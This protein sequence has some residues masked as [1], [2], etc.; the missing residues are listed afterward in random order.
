M[1]TTKI[2]MCVLCV[3][4]HNIY[5]YICTSNTYIYIYYMCINIY[6]HNICTQYIHAQYMY[7]SKT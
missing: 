5:I 2:Y 1:L 7:I 4:T 6:T 3:C